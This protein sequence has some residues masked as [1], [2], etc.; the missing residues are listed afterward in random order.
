MADAPESAMTS[1]ASALR[2]DRAWRWFSPSSVVLLLLSLAVAT[3]AAMLAR[4]TN[5]P[6]TA[7][8][9]FVITVL[10]NGSVSGLVHGL[11]AAIF[12]SIVYNFFI[13][14]P[15]YLHGFNAIDDVFPIFA[16][17]VTAILSGA[18]S[19]K[20]RDRMIAADRARRQ[21]TRLF[22]YS[23][24]LQRAVTLDQIVRA[25]TAAVPD[26]RALDSILDKVRAEA[27][28][29]DHR[30]WNQ[31]VSIGLAGDAEG[32][33]DWPE[34]LSG[35]DERAIA[36]LTAMAIERC[37]L[38]EEHASA[39]AVLNSERVKTALLSS[40]SHDLRTPLAAISAM[41]GT[42]KSYGGVIAEAERTEMLETILE[43]CDRLDGFTGKL[44]SLGRLE[45]GL[46]SDRFEMVDVEEVL[47]SVIAAA[48]S[49]FP[50]RRIVRRIAPEA[51]LTMA[52]PVLL[53]QALFNV[54]ENAVRYSEPET[55]VQVTLDRTEEMV[56][57]TI[58]DQGVGIALADLP[59]IFERFYRGG[60]GTGQAGHGLGLA[61]TKTFLDI[62]GG[63]IV[64]TSPVTD[65]RGT[66]VR[67]LLPRTMAETT[68]DLND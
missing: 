27:S 12:V 56:A 50:Q 52:S 20:L 22:D 13:R 36:S 17:T 15:V 21:L 6:V 49:A 63:R 47:G 64:V 41:A 4:D 11:I 58:V 19:G 3:P 45:A 24:E 54:L 65:G 48:R 57:I 7:A 29:P 25:L 34:R 31:A 51:F 39:Q 1:L 42:L 59:H 60:D 33:A 37:E 16:L 38:L 43:Q 28:L 44:L 23:N 62:I 8:L 46:L 35:T 26:G 9:I 40:L 5:H 2:A 53:E 68:E 14:F 67:I 32:G 61:I 66:Q 55:E 30:R 10:V 18:I